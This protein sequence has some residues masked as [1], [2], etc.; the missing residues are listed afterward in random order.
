MLFQRY[1]ICHFDSIRKINSIIE[2]IYGKS[3]VRFVIQVLPHRDIDSF[4]INNIYQ[5]IL[6]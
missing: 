3:L 2:G 4:R 5:Q 6:G 1:E